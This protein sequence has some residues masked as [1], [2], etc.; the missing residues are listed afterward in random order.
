M[1][2]KNN[3]FTECINCNGTDHVELYSFPEAKK[4]IMKCNYCEMLSLD[5]KPTPEELRQVYSDSYYDNDKLLEKEIGGIYGYVDYISE[6]INKQSCYKRILSYINRY[7]VPG[8]NPSQLLDYGCG[9]GHFLDI[10]YDFNHEVYGVEFNQSAIDYIEKRYKYNVQTVDAYNSSTQQFNVIT[11]FDVIEH[12]LEPSEALQR[13][14]EKLK[15]NGILVLTTTHARSITSKLLG[16]RLEDFRRISEHIF[17]FSPKNLSEM[18]YKHG[19]EVLKI[20]SQGHSFQLDMLCDRLKNTSKIAHGCLKTLLNV[21]P[22]LKR[23]SIY[24]NPLTKFTLY[25]RKVKTGKLPEQEFSRKK[26]SIIMPAYNEQ[27]YLKTIVSKVLSIDYGMDYELIIVDDGSKDRTFTIAKELAADPRIK[28]YTIPHAGKGAAVYEGIRKSIGDYVVIQDADL[29]Y[30]PEDINK[31][32]NTV[33]ETNASV[34]YGTRFSGDYRRTGSF[35]YTLGNKFLTL[36][37]NLTC[38]LNL[39]DM[40]TCYKLFDGDLIRS[41]KIQ[42]KKFDFEPEITCKLSRQKIALYET[43][44]SYEARTKLQGKKIGFSDGIQ[45][46][47]AIF[48]Y[49]F[50]D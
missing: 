38:G 12:L 44:I 14:A 31:L 8:L 15:H 26:L 37:T 6:R 3:E 35:I 1:V 28:P 50:F 45:A 9:L 40:E 7:N 36:L 21:L 18:L 10:A 41:V 24:I 16:K 27:T 19:F 47:Y 32:L 13:F 48:K 20:H 5:P 43:P 46:I 23:V 34:V 11:S 33:K 25:A 30:N 17:F 4:R 2:S 42:S 39:T 22:F 29:E 49:R